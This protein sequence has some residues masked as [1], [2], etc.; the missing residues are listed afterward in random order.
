M[1]SSTSCY[2]C[3]RQY[4]PEQKRCSCGEPVW[5]DV[6]VSRFEPPRNRSRGVWS[7][8]DV[9]PVEPRDDL[10]VASGGTPLFRASGLDEFAGCRVFLKDETQNPTGSFK[11]RGS[12]VAVGATIERGKPWI[13]TVSHGNMA[14]STAAHAAAA[15]LS[16]AVFVPDDVS[17]ERLAA[18]DQYDPEI[19]RISGD[20]GRLYRETIAVDRSEIE[21]VNSDTPLR[22]EGQKTIAYEIVE[23]FD[24]DGPDA[25]VLPVSSGGQASAIWKALR[26]L[27]EAGVVETL[28]RLY[29]A[30]AAACDPIAA[31]YRAGADEVRAI[32]PGKTIAYSIANADPP[33]GTRALAAVRETGGAVVSVPDDEIQTAQAAFARCAGSCVEPAS[34]TALAGLAR[35]SQRGAISVDEKIVVVA[36]GSGFKELGST[37]VDDGRMTDV[38]AVQLTIDAIVGADG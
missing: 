3:G 1:V 6:D 30:Q 38:S 33:S 9:L 27:R 14:M 7:Y 37:A 15:D 36:T 12:A 21:F 25:I 17:D 28:P 18:I 16:C 8:A 32:D 29:L 35:L 24:G 4:G 10:G 5:F 11:D 13:G 23:D 22:I 34:A 2:A 26:E 20:Y 31:A 19:V